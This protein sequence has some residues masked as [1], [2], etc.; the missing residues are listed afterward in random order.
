M[1]YFIRRVKQYDP[2]RKF[3]IAES[4][5]RHQRLEDILLLHKVYHSKEMLCVLHKW[6]KFIW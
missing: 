4:L 5:W 6:I 2:I 3:T 1:K